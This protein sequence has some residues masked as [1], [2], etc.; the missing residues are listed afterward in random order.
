MGLLGTC[1]CPKA[2]VWGA[3]FGGGGNGVVG[4]SVAGIEWHW[5]GW[6]ERQCNDQRSCGPTGHCK[7]FGFA[8]RGAV[9]GFEQRREV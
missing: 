4:A 9:E 8:L 6:S 7:D 5:R 1:A 3:Y 2:E